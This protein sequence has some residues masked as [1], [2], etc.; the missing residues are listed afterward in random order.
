[1]WTPFLFACFP[2]NAPGSRFL[3][4]GFQPQAPSSWA[5]SLNI[6][7]FTIS[8]VRFPAFP[9]WPA[10]CDILRC[11]FRFTIRDSR[12]TIFYLPA[13]IFL[14]FLFFILC[15]M[16]YGLFNVQGSMLG[17]LPSMAVLSSLSHLPSPIYSRLSRFTFRD[18]S[19]ALSFLLTFGP[20]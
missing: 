20:S 1:M 2:L 5:H 10:T 6:S 15:P 16:P 7:R 17:S 19:F 12:F 3:F 4:S 8:N 18:L 11:A 14:R 9:L 13:S